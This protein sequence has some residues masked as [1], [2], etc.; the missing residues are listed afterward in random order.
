[1]LWCVYVCKISQA[2]LLCLNPLEGLEKC[3]GTVGKCC[4]LVLGRI[5]ELK[6][7]EWGWQGERIY[8][9]RGK[10]NAA[11]RKSTLPLWLIVKSKRKPSSGRLARALLW[12]KKA[13][14]RKRP[15]EGCN[16]Q[17]N[18]WERGSGWDYRRLGTRAVHA[19]KI[20][21]VEIGAL[22]LK[23]SYSVFTTAIIALC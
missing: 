20:R 11:H 19:R 22:L 2:L 4:L 6:G 21:V 18:G 9:A 14:S 23:S 16:L 13:Q 5:M 17:V 12:M 3:L 10:Q 7:D 1:M 8:R 15:P